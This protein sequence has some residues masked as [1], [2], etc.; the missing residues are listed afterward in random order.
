MNNFF[1]EKIEL[2]DLPLIRKLILEI[3]GI[4]KKNESFLFDNLSRREYK[5]IEEILDLE[6]DVSK[7]DLMDIEVTVGFLEDAFGELEILSLK[8]TDSFIIK[9]AESMLEDVSYLYSRI[10]KL[11]R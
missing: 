1:K 5:R 10:L 9:K 7:F 2:K 11:L 6:N 8:S 4:F 3:I